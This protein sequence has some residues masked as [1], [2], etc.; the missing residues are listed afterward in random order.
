MSECL[1]LP[2]E[3]IMKGRSRLLFI[4]LILTSFFSF[5][6]E[7]QHFTVTEVAGSNIAKIT[8][9]KSVEALDATTAISLGTSV[10]DSLSTNSDYRLWNDLD[11]Y[12]L[13]IYTFSAAV[14]QRATITMESEDFD[15]FLYL[16]KELEE[17]VSDFTLTDVIASNDDYFRNTLNSKIDYNIEETGT[18]YIV[19]SSN[20][21]AATGNYNLVLEF[22]AAGPAVTS[23][24]LIDR[25]LKGNTF[26]VGWSWFSGTYV[27]IELYQGN[28][29]ISELAA[30][31]ANS[32]FWIGTFPDDLSDGTYRIKVT[33]TSDSSQSAYS[34]GF[35]IGNDPA[36][37]PYVGTPSV[38]SPI[39]TDIWLPGETYTISWSGF[40]ASHVNICLDNYYMSRFLLSISNAVVNNG[41]YSWTVP[42]NLSYSTYYRIVIRTNNYSQKTY[43][44]QFTIG[45]NP[46]GPPRVISPTATDTWLP[47]E[48]YTISWSGFVGSHVIIHLNDRN[49]NFSTLHISD[50]AINNGSYSWTVPNNLSYSPSC[51]IFIYATDNSHDARSL[52]FTIGSRYF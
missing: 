37:D 2:E 41:S 36:S 8:G 24:T 14:G 39:A 15:T 21:P 28:T 6:I 10:A 22:A 9:T 35:T 7:E 18:H 31:A 16:Y 30:S 17:S 50:S 32:G 48:T 27:K 20:A 12:Y 46:E 13:K 49:F 45:S 11:K 25:Y 51:Q 52:L 34:S 40:S 42:N 38:I 3:V 4:P 44:H 47:G 33:S 19:A 23:P 1:Q 29:C 26:T 5:C 43:S